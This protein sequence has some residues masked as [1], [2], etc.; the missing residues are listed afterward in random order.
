[1]RIEATHSKEGFKAVSVTVVIE[2]R[3]EV[4]ALSEHEELMTSRAY[5]NEDITAGSATILRDLVD[6]LYNVAKRA[7][8]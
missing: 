4:K 1:M 6:G 7:Q 5:E 2:T 3:E 8:T